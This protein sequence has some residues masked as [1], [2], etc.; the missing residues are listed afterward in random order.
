MAHSSGGGSSSSSI[1]PT[2]PHP[3]QPAGYTQFPPP[4]MGQYN[5]F[6]SMPYFGRAPPPPQMM[7]NLPM[8]HAQMNQVCLNMTRYIHTCIS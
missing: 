1:L 2:P 6:G 7:M 4:G 8:Q 3:V 5:P